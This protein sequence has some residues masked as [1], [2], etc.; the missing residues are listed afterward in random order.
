MKNEQL[1]N[2]EIKSLNEEKGIFEGY[3]STFGNEDFVGDVVCKGAYQDFLSKKSVHD[4]YM[5]YQ[6]DNSEIIGKWLEMREDENG[7]Y[8]KG[9]L[10]INNIQRA[11][12]TLFLMKENLLRKMSIG[13]QIVE[14]A[15]EGGVRMLKK[16]NL[17]EVSIVT[18][19]AN[20]K[21]DVLA[22]KQS[23]ALEKRDFEKIL[24]DAGLSKKDAKA[25]IADGYKALNRDDLNTKENEE[26]VKSDL[27]VAE[28]AEIAKELSKFKF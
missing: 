5:F 26:E 19:P 15:F 10:F 9:Q 11:K 16:L 13:Y 2:F 18:F 1:V 20:D 23:E 7:L 24:R 6:H 27:T 28:C 12:E 14:K 17:K 21:A 3:A 25:F 8:V 4:V 22:V